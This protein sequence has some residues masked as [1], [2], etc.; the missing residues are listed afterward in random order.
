MREKE[1]KRCR[2]A[3]VGSA[4]GEKLRATEASEKSGRENEKEEWRLRREPMG[5]KRLTSAQKVSTC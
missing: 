1:G 5:G 2:A 3:I 4:G